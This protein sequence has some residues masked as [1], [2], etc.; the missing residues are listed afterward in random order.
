MPKLGRFKSKPPAGFEQIEQTLLDFERRMRVAETESH[1]GKRRSQLTWNVTRVHHDRSRF[2]YEMHFK[3]REISKQLYDWLVKEKFADGALIA[4]WR[5][6]GYEKLCCVQCIQQGHNFGGVCV[7]RVP[8]H[9]RS[10]PNQEI[11]CKTCGCRGCASGDKVDQ[12]N[13]SEES[14]V[15]QAQEAER[16]QSFDADSEDD[17]KRLT[18]QGTGNDYG[19]D[20]NDENDEN[21]TSSIAEQ[22]HGDA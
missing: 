9:L 1:D 21:D 20:N 5:K 18:E 3:K 12:H 8:R 10:N 11:E 6:P 22:Q 15:C 14:D 4:K 2:V 16:S 7:C 13:A 19:D 17:E